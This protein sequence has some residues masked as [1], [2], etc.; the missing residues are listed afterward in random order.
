LGN[1]EPE[2]ATLTF[3]GQEGLSVAPAPIFL[4]SEL[5]ANRFRV[6]RFLG[7]GGMAQVFEAEDLEL[8]QNVAI[9]V[10]RPELAASLRAR[11]LLRR[12]VLLARRVTHPNVCRIFDVFHHHPG[13]PADPTDPDRPASDR[14]PAPANL[15]LVME[16]LAGPTLAQRLAT[17]GPLPPSAALPVVRQLAEALDAAHRSAVV[18]GD[19]KSGNVILESGAAG[20]RAVVTDFGLAQHAQHAATAGG[21]AGGTTAYMA[22]EQRWQGE[23]TPASDIY[24][25]GVVIYE[26]VLGRRPS[27]GPGDAAG[28]AQFF[29][30]PAGEPDPGQLPPGWREVLARCLAPKPADR[31]A[32]ALEVARALAAALPPAPVLA[33]APAPP[34]AGLRRFLPSWSQAMAVLLLA[35]LGLLTHGRARSGRAPAASSAAPAA[36]GALAVLAPA[37]APAAPGS[38]PDSARTVPV[39]LAI[40]VGSLVEQ[41]PGSGAPWLGAALGHMVL[42]EIGAGEQVEA[43]QAVAAPAAPIAAGVSPPAAGPPPATG[44]G[45]GRLDADLL[46]SGSFAL[47][48]RAGATADPAIRIELRMTR[49]PEGAVLASCGDA[50]QLADVAAVV[51]RLGAR[52]RRAIGVAEPSPEDRLAALARRPATLQAEG[53]YAQGVSLLQRGEPLAAAS[54][55]DLALAADPAFSLSH[56]AQARAFAEL[57]Y[58][59]RAKQEALRAAQPVERLPEQQKLEIAAIS[60][61][62]ND[63]LSGAAGLYRTLWRFAP[64]DADYG[65]QLAESQLASGEAS[66]ALETLHLIRGHGAPAALAPRVELLEARARYAISDFPAALASALAAEDAAKRE[67][68]AAVLAAAQLAEA[69]TRTE[70]GDADNAG[71]AL[72][73]ARDFYRR[74]GHRGG[75]AEAVQRLAVL[76][77]RAGRLSEAEA[78]NRQALAVFEDIGSTRGAARA[79][80]AMGRDKLGLDT[81]AARSLLERAL[82]GYRTVAD[83]TGAAHALDDLSLAASDGGDPERAERLVEEAVSLYAETGDRMGLTRALTNLSSYEAPRGELHAARQ[84]VEEALRIS[85]ELGWKT[86][87]AIG[88]INLG[89]LHFMEGNLH[90]AGPE[91]MNGRRLA[92]EAN[93]PEN[94]R[95]ALISLSA[96]LVQEGKLS[97]AESALGMALELTRGKSNPIDGEALWE[98]A[99]VRLWEGR[100]RDAEDSLRSYAKVPLAAATNS[101]EL[102]VFAV[103]EAGQGRLAAARL[104]I[105]RALRSAGADPET[106]VLVAIAAAR[107]ELASGQPAAAAARLESVLKRFAAYPFPQ[108]FFEARLLLAR[109]RL[110]Q[111]LA[112]AACPDLRALA[113]QTHRQRFEL[114]ARQADR[115]LGSPST[116]CRPVTLQHG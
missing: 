17:G 95:L 82:A 91:F 38:S 41:P 21:C 109:S 14:E 99:R 37:S 116:G 83:R 40:A 102:A 34:A 57:G 75:E 42:S 100:Y 44:Q 72:A 108:Y 1:A 61:R 26:M 104:A 67:G 62:A 46:V 77:H 45:R 5:A 30:R 90:G 3:T 98:L 13:L 93:S 56:A 63:D 24:A 101:R 55:L 114:V 25:L 47:V 73:A 31:P 8:G 15:V 20:P 115:L 43:F 66:S 49:L 88:H 107:V 4:P 76:A 16:L 96:A 71:R 9:K 6:V 54:A 94:E 105:E 23:V 65:L 84:H 29:P 59:D 113:E 74:I 87:Q 86:G 68:N 39:R 48:R 36:V 50:G 111:G 7:Q 70:D 80:A 97:L 11:E 52:L 79:L 18:H 85:E 19:F 81:G 51:A 32:T 89:D 22:P 53:H 110:D 35:C 58:H 112:A 69:D 60:R 12:E 78:L 2:T 33:P 27:P 106:N 103:A 64:H 28:A 10:I 92:R